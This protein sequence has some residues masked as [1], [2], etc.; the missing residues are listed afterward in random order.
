MIMIMVIIKISKASLDD[1]EAMANALLEVKSNPY[2]FKA[3][4]NWETK[5]W[6]PKNPGNFIAQYEPIALVTII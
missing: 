5:R 3:R 6:G 4:K 1:A 2:L